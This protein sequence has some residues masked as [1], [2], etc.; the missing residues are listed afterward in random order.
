M[1][2]EEQFIKE[3]ETR[4]SPNF[5]QFLTAEEWNAR[6]APSAEDEQKIVD[7]AQSQGLTVTNRFANRL[8]VDVEAPVGVIEKAFGVTI[9]NYQV[10]DEVDF[11]NDRDPV[12]P[13]SVANVVYAVLGLNSIDR[14]HGTSPA[15]KHIK[16]PDYV[17]GPVYAAGESSHGDGDPTKRVSKQRALSSDPRHRPNSPTIM[18][19]PVISSVRKPITGT[20][21][22]CTATAATCITTPAVLRKK[23]RSPWPHSQVSTALM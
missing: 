7:W 22:R 19:T 18:P 6:F 16:G 1:A 12:L 2:E 5:H 14:V 23:P 3:L 21:C 11:A 8:L 15:N 9:N 20:A 17:P 10:G 13:S 4:G